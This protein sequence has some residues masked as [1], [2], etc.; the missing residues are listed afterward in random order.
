MDGLLKLPRVCALVLPTRTFDLDGAD[1]SIREIL[2]DKVELVPYEEAKATAHTNPV[3]AILSI[4]HAKVDGALIDELSP[5]GTLKLV[6]NYG[7]GVDHINLQ[8]CRERGVT[9][10]NTPDCVTDATADM[11]WALLMASARRIVQ[12]DRYCRTEYTGYKNMIFLGSDVSHATLGIIGMG[13]IG[14]QIAWRGTGFH[15][16]ILYHNRTR[17]EEAEAKIGVKYA[18]LDD[19]LRESDYVVLACPSTP[20]TRHLINKDTL[21]KMKRSAVLINVGRG[22]IVNTD[23]LVQALRDG[24]IA[25]AGL[26]VTDPEPLPLD[27]PLNTMD[28]VTLAPHRGSATKRARDGLRDIMIANLLAGLKGDKPLNPCN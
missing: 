17:K 2:R 24:V 20:E 1:P 14:E 21:A 15:M 25:H 19:L 4:S 22:P 11:A 13:R 5:N 16:K 6:A 10:T 7:V 18:S 9:V 12:G 26:D 27:H 23:D 28:C 8:E 3:Q